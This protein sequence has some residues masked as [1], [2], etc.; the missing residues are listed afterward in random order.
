MCTLCSCVATRL[1]GGGAKASPENFWMNAE[2]ERLVKN[3]ISKRKRDDDRTERATGGPVVMSPPLSVDDVAALDRAVSKAMIH[4]SKTIER[5]PRASTVVSRA[6]VQLVVAITR[7]ETSLFLCHEASVFALAAW[8][9][10]A[11][12]AAFFDQNQHM[13]WTALN[14]RVLMTIVRSVAFDV[15][16]DS[17][18]RRQARSCFDQFTTSNDAQKVLVFAPPEVISSVIEAVGKSSIKDIVIDS[19]VRRAVDFL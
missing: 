15:K 1:A 5:N 17:L 14:D 12:E 11:A 4:V 9:L 2:V 10:E 18:L 7:Y 6:A 16:T 3:L 13:S 8:S 19:G